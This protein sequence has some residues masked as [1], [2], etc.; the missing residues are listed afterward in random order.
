MES[1][2]DPSAA[3]MKL[4][5]DGFRAG[6][7]RHQLRK[8]T[9]ALSDGSV[10]AAQLSSGAFESAMRGVLA[11]VRASSRVHGGLAGVE[12]PSDSVANELTSCAGPALEALSVCTIGLRTA[13]ASE[14]PTGMQPFTDPF[15]E[16]PMPPA[17]GADFDVV[18][19]P[20]VVVEAASEVVRCMELASDANRQ[21]ALCLAE[22]TRAPRA[23]EAAAGAS[24]GRGV[25][26]VCGMLQQATDTLDLE[27]MTGTIASLA[28]VARGSTESAALCSAA[29]AARLASQIVGDF[30]QEDSSSQSSK[31]LLPLAI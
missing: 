15:D 21:A 28:N 2:D 10:R 5:V 31:S 29:G 27:T 26:I 4:K 23:A 3:L 22:L 18:A 9:L 13:L 24:D 25:E 19:L 11:A 17:E 6:E 30:A 1:A 16:I 7:L 14:N 20:A 12:A 8:V